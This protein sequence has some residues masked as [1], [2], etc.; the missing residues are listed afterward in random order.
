VTEGAG[1]HDVA[2]GTFPRFAKKSLGQNFLVD[3]NISRKIVSASSISHDD[4]VIEIGPGKGALTR[5]LVQSGAR[6]TAIEKDAALAADLKRELSGN[7]NLDVVTGD[8][9][10]YEFPP[11]QPRCKVIGNIP[12]NLTSV[13]VSRL[14]DER[15]KI[16]SA[17][18]MVQD[19]VARRLAAEPGTK[20][21]GSISI[22]LQL[23][24]EV[25][26]L[27]VVTPGCFRPVPKVDS[28]VVIIRFKGGSPLDDEAE[29]VRFV[30]SAFGMRRKMFRHFVASKFG[31]GAVELLDE[32]FRTRRVETFTPSEIYD[33][34]AI[35]ENNVRHK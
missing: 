14:V 34:F 6:I 13:I 20:E 11:G 24:S 23:V 16:Q 35:L 30:K 2:R 28:R 4:V 33:I 25:E 7:A 5:F 1:K 22:R 17:V 32:K 12:Y 10:E 29:F 3:D 18:L 27:F 21:Y 19:E 9:L 26:R 8:F 31:K 15:E